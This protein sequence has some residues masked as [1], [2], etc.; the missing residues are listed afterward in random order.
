MAYAF[1]LVTT[2]VQFDGKA[3]PTRRAPDFNEQGD[4]ILAEELGLDWDTIVDLKMHGVV[5]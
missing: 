3:S 2:P 1:K 5:A 4:D